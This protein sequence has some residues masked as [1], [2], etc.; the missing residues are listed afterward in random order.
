MKTKRAK[1]T[2][3]KRA[4]ARARLLR[5]NS[6]CIFTVYLGLWLPKS[7]SAILVDLAATS[8]PA[9]ALP[10]WKNTGTVAGDSN[11]PA[12]AVPSVTTVGPAKGVTFNG[13]TQYYTGPAAPAEVTGGNSRT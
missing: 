8:A 12:T 6:G 5:R 9:G 7:C 4:E 11:A 10:T 3:R 1:Q 2:L 13:S